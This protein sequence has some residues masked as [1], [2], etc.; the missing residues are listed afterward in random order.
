MVR[1]R[2]SRYV[3]LLLDT[4]AFAWIIDDEAVGNRLEESAARLIGKEPEI[5]V[6]AVSFYEIGLKVWAGK[7]PEMRLHL[8][9][10]AGLCDGLDIERLPLDDAVSLRAAT[11]DWPHRDPFDRLIVATALHLDC[12]IVTTDRR[13]DAVVET[14]R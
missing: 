9:N 2:R 5:C 1:R 6:S 10:L 3:T 13:F 11:L 12:P 8:S 7:W 14:V 4:N